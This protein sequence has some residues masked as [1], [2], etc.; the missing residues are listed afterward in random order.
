M[1]QVNQHNIVPRS[2]N[3]YYSPIESINQL[4]NQ[5]N[6]RIVV[7][8]KIKSLSYHINTVII[9]RIY[10]KQS[11]TSYTGTVE[12]SYTLGYIQKELYERGVKRYHMVHPY[13]DISDRHH[14]N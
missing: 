13:N 3:V 9:I 11:C 8:G 12:L 4:I 14:F 2:T 1:S 7:D 5:S 10:G 6:N